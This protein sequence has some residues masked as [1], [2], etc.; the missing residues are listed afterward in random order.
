MRSR[1][2]MTFVIFILLA[3]LLGQTVFGSTEQN[4][5]KLVLQITV[6]QM[7]GDLPIA[8]PLLWSWRRTLVL[9]PRGLFCGSEWKAH[10][11]GRLN[12]RNIPG[13][14][15]NTNIKNL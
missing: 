12:R 2:F 10:C 5:P 1:I 14:L 15:K 3:M 6:D 7:R 11:A 13:I 9:S 4:Q 8:F